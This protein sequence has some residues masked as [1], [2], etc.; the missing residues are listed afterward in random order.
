MRFKKPVVALSAAALLA[1]AACGGGDDNGGNGGGADG[2]INAEDLGNTGSG[3]DPERE[4]PVTIEG[5]EEG[6]TVTVLTNLGLTTPIDPS[7]IYYV[8]TNAIMTGLVTRQLTQYAYDEESDSMI[9]VPDLA[10]DLGTPNEDFT[11]WQ[12]TIRDGVRWENGDPV[13]AEEVA[14]GI[15]RSMDAKTFP[16]GPGLYYSNPYFLGGDTYKG[17]YTGNDPDGTKQEAVT[18]DGNT[19]TIKMSKPFPDFPYYGT[20]PAMGAVPL[21]DASDPAKYNQ[22]PLSNG[23]YKFKSYTT[24]KSLVLERNP[25]W[26]PATD[27]AR[28]AYPDGYEFKA[29]VQADQIDQIIMGDSGEGQTTLTYE[30][31]QAQNFR[32]FQ[33]ESPE[34]L[35]TGTSPCT[36][37]SAPDYRKIT[38]KKVR[39]AL[40]WA[41]PY[42]DTILATGEIPN[43]TAIPAKNIMVPG[44]PGREEFNPVEGHEDFQTDAAKAKA[45]LEEAGAL[46]TEIRFLWRTDNELN[47][48]SKDVLVKALEEAGFKATPVATTEANYVAERDNPKTDINWR[49]AGWCADWPSGATWIPP[50]FQT[51]DYE[52]IGQVGTNYS[53]F[54]EAD[55]DAK[56]EEAFTQPTD[57]QPAAWNALDEE[58]MTEYLPVVPQFYSG[59]AMIHGSRIQGMNNDNTLGEPTYKS[60]WIS[61]Q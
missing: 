22:R 14:F 45:L 20:F 7:D 30:D 38:D 40:F 50:L 55:I 44:T 19:V 17:P 46:G 56:I 4:G 24:A 29:G 6:G 21:G 37:Y 47:T 26:D 9:L 31:V 41:Y 18:V 2:G 54:S 25:E 60:L 39:E 23:P 5:A 13:T 10:T 15:V 1:L 49:S 59:V 34:R 58:I 8:D 61:G 35:V 28:T 36:F 42:R 48:K 51:V 52:E 27:P 33:Q 53:I 16:N 43:V 57:E 3:Q 32:K 11:E 12:F